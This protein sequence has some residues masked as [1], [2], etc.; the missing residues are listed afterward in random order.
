MIKDRKD[1]TNALR[2]VSL[3]PNSPVQQKDGKWEVSNR[4]ETWKNI[5]PRISDDHLDRLKAVAIEVLKEKDPQFDLEASERFAAAIHG[6]ITKHSRTLRKGL[7]ETLALLGSDPA[8]LTSCS[9]GK[10][11]GTAVLAVREILKDADTTLWASLNDCLETLAEA[12]PTEFLDAVEKS[13]QKSPSPFSGVF[14]EE[15][16]GFAGRNY[17]SGLL[18][19]LEALAWSPDYLARATVIFGELAALDPGGNWA[20]RPA[21][22]LVDVFLPWHPQTCADISR[23]KAAIAA[24][25]REQ[26]NVGWRLLLALLPTHTGATSGTYKPTWRNFIRAGWSETVTQKDYWEQVSVYAE[27]A[28]G[29]AMKDFSRL[30]ELVNHIPSLPQPSGPRL[31]EYLSSDSIA[32]LS[33]EQRKPLWEA[34]AELTAKHRQFPEA[35]WVMPQDIIKKLETIAATL[36]PK[37]P[38][39]NARRLFIS[40]EWSLYNS[41]GSFD[42]QVKALSSKRQEAVGEIMKAGGLRAILDFARE[43]ES[44]GPVG[45]ALGHIAPSSYDADLLPNSLRSDEKPV[46]I[47]GGGFAFGRLLSKGRPW[48]NSMLAKDWTVSQK[49]DLLLALPFKKETWQRATKALGGDIGLYW[50]NARILPPGEK[51]EALEAAKTLVEFGRPQEALEC[52]NRLVY[53]KTDFPPELAARALLE[54]LKVEEASAKI[55]QYNIEEL[56]AWLQEHPP[57]DENILF[58]IEWAYLPLLGE[59]HQAKPRTLESRLATTPDFFCEIVRACFRSD[60]IE[61]KDQK[62]TEAQQNIAN[63]AYRLLQEWTLVPGADGKGGFDGIAFAK[64]LAE[65]RRISKQSG[66]LAIT[67]DLVGKVLPYAPADLSGLWIHHSVAE[68]LNAIESEEMREGFTCKLF[69]MRGVHGFTAGKAELA[70]AKNYHKRADA[71]DEKGFQRFAASMRE[72]AKSYERDA[73]YQSKRNPFKD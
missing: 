63:N 50:K 16:G 46:K 1:W 71:L 49:A 24:L 36:A 28:V 26:P 17:T 29:M 56:I 34:L 51:E 67:M 66:H 47:L 73:E 20:N 60:K 42:D 8:A 15:S 40:K 23:R 30:V 5:G 64:W 22:S 13:L 62:P 38:R 53:L 54:Y 59:H 7:A 32:S 65:V 27:L 52:I 37:A 6:K 39:L 10:A 3:L 58:R 11:E 33:D 19:G 45:V 70:L 35:K 41:K 44:P 61:A 31:V 69:N 14:A 57:A 18:W 68:A 25:L 55:D 4:K 72:F 9:H 48:V 2:D 12:A 21:N 43:V